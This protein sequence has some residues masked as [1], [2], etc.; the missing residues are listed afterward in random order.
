MPSRNPNPTEDHAGRGAWVCLIFSLLF[1]S[2]FYCQQLPNN[3]DFSRL[4]IWGVIL[5][6]VLLTPNES[7]ESGR[8]AASIGTSQALAQRVP[9]V[10][11]AAILLLSAWILGS[12]TQTLLCPSFHFLWSERVAIRFGT[13]LSWLS[14]ITLIAG[15]AGQL[16][17][18]AILLPTGISA[19]VLLFMVRSGKTAPSHPKTQVDENFVVPKKKLPIFG[20]TLSLIMLSTFLGYLLLGSLSPPSDFDV[21][22]YHLQGPKE[23]FQSGHIYYLSHNVYTSFPFMTEMISLAGMILLQ[24]WW[25]GALAGKFVL[26]CFAPLTSLC[27]YSIARRYAGLTPA[28][29]AVIIHLTTPWT[30]RISLI[31]YAEGALTFY[32]TATTMLGLMFVLHKQ[33]QHQSQGLACLLG[34]LAGSAMA[35]KYT[36]LISVIVPAFAFTLIASIKSCP[37]LKPADSMTKASGQFTGFRLAGLFVVGICLTVGPWL[38]RNLADTGNPV[39]PLA[40]GV[41][42]G[43][44]WN[45]EIDERWKTAHSAPEHQISRIPQHFLDAAVRNDWTSPLLFAFLLPSVAM[46]FG[47]RQLQILWLIIAWQ[48]L[49]WWAL[50]HRIDR[51]WIPTIPLLAVTAGW[52][53]QY[54]AS[55]IWRQGQLLVVAICTLF[56]LRFC[57]LPLIGFH[58]GL[59]DITVTRQIPIRSDF[60]ELNRTMTTEN[61]V[62]MVGEAEVFDATFPVV[63]NTVFDDSIFEEWASGNPSVSGTETTAMAH[64]LAENGITHIMVNWFEILRYRLPGSYGYAEFVQPSRINQ[65]VESGLL[66]PPKILLARP[67]NSFTRQELGILKSWEEGDSLINSS[68]QVTGGLLYEVLRNDATVTRQP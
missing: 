27:V 44:E 28:L 29:L 65:L 56:N 58:A 23:W 66:S 50:T 4:D 15:L 17:S 12:L 10:F 34:L 13:G 38:A 6:E 26:A 25:T 55:R 31:A 7:P 57:L 39:F 32:L 53:W 16:T 63:Y 20:A 62:L 18:W 43:S 41:F 45:S 9:M 40:Y 61:K 33:T 48:F 5:D 49:T 51:F 21:R 8:D 67:I 54:Y 42:G 46:A 2:F 35:C 36:G 24:D 47:N 11:S 19:V 60:R 59:N 64:K 3:P 30:L 52:T 68:D 22:E 37:A 14:L 1:C